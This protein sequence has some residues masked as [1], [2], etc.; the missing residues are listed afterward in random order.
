MTTKR[1]QMLR[2]L[3]LK[4]CKDNERYYSASDMYYEPLDAEEIRSL[5][6][7]LIIELEGKL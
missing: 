2:N 5:V 7:F 3:I 6:D 1:K 4:W